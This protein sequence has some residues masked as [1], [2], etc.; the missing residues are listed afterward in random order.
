MKWIAKNNTNEP[1]SLR[2]FRINTPN[3][4]FNGIHGS[5]KNDIRTA[6][7]KEQGAICAYCMRR[8]S[9]THTGM[10]IEH[11]IPQNRH[12]NSPHSSAMHIS[13][14]LKY[15]NML[16]TCNGIRKCSEIRGNFPLMISPL[17]KKCETLVKF[18][19]DGRAYSEDPTINAEIETLELN[20]L[21]DLR[22]I[23]IDKAREELMSLKKEGT[24]SAKIINNQIEKWKCLKKTRH[25]L[26]YEEYCMAAVHYLA[27]KKTI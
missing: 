16:G 4:G 19:K 27:S 12:I 9:A 17:N 18:L 23:V 8:I 22:K 14:R 1:K 25:G 5:I 20:K 11:L 3:A 10:E 21:S 2:E 15:L 13:S 26:A 7:L 6:L 24:W